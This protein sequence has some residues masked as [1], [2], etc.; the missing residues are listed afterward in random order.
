MSPPPH[1]EKD[2]KVEGRD[3]LEMGP[4]ETI[5][6]FKSLLGRLLRV[7]PNEVAEQQRLFDSFRSGR[8][9]EPGKPKKTKDTILPAQNL[10]DGQREEH[11]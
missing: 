2:A 4:K 11:K 5:A 1:R 10:K 6:P 3:P 7:K 9:D 8:F